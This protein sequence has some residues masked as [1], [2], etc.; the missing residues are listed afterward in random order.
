MSKP[1]WIYDVTVETNSPADKAG[2][3]SVALR[4]LLHRNVQ[5]SLALLATVDG[6]ESD[7]LLAI[8]QQQPDWAHVMNRVAAAHA[9]NYIASNT[10]SPTQGIHISTS[11]ITETDYT[12]S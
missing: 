8:Y 9:L 3:T 1:R 10:N 11:L 4:R 2:V 12:I 5:P 7:N 6:I